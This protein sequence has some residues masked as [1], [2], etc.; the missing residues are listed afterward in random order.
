MAG[1]QWSPRDLPAS[2][3]PGSDGWCVRNAYCDL[4]RW[5]AGSAEWSRFIESPHPDDLLPLARH[6][7]V[8][9]YDVGVAEH[10][11][12]LI[13]KL[14]HPGIAVFDIPAAAIGHAVCVPHVHALLHHW[15]EFGGHPRP[16]LPTFGW[17]LGP[18]HLRHNPKVF[19]VIVDERQ[20]ARPLSRPA[21]A[22]RSE[23]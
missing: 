23:R 21:P 10:W 16:D 1:F 12:A 3:V 20:P 17:P 8:T 4:L 2:P 7:G 11:N 5:P 13:G 22:G 19:W 18:E 9:V 15:P 6:L 14:D